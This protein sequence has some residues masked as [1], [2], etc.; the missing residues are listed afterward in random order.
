MIEYSPALISNL[1]GD[2][3][4]DV[5]LVSAPSTSSPVS[6]HLNLELP[7]KEITGE[8][9]E[10]NTTDESRDND[11]NDKQE[12]DI[13]GEIVGEHDSHILTEEKR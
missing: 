6:T 4:D 1:H 12:I 13:S 11:N 10:E 7:V 2:L 8:R 5:L 9:E 3:H